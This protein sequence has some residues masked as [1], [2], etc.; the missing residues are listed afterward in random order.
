VAVA[1]PPV[2]QIPTP[3]A[4]D[5]DQ[6][7]K[8]KLSHGNLLRLQEQAQ[9][10]LDFF[11]NERLGDL[12]EEKNLAGTRALLARLRPMYFTDLVDTWAS[13]VIWLLRLEA[14]RLRFRIAALGPPTPTS[15]EDIAKMRR[16]VVARA[17]SQLESQVGDVSKVIADDVLSKLRAST[18]EIIG[19]ELVTSMDTHTLQ[20]QTYEEQINGVCKVAIASASQCVRTWV[21]SVLRREDELPAWPS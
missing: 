4:T 8:Q 14:R 13:P 6:A 20:W 7:E 19:N 5:R 9:K 17:K 12:L 16:G 1:N 15:R 3:T 11:K 10:E 18:V 2:H 21:E